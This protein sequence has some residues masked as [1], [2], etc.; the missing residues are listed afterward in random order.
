MKNL[1]IG[2]LGYGGE[3]R[4]GSN[5]KSSKALTYYCKNACVS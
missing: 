2:A 4:T 5:I 1:I 3:F